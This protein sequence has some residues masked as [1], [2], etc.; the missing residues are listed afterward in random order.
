MTTLSKKEQSSNSWNRPSESQVGIV[1]RERLST[2]EN[3]VNTMNEPDYHSVPTLGVASSADSP[4]AKREK[5]ANSIRKVAQFSGRRWAKEM[6]E[7]DRGRN[8]LTLVSRNLLDIKIELESIMTAGEKTEFDSLIW[9]FDGL[10]EAEISKSAQ[11]F[12]KG[13]CDLHKGL[14]D[15]ADWL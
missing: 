15:F 4:Q 9:A 2:Q 5:F 8:L 3:F 6:P 1:D 13:G 14:C 12:W 11:P 7:T 10:R